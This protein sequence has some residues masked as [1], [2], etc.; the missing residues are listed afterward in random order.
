MKREQK[1][2][3]QSL[4]SGMILMLLT[5]WFL[6]LIVMIFAMIFLVTDRIDSQIERSIETS[7]QKAAEILEMQLEASETASKNA[8]YLSVIRNAYIS[9]QKGGDRGE[10]QNTI[11]SFI[12]Q[13]YKFNSNVKSVVLVFMEYPE[14][15][16]FTFNNSNNGTYNDIEFFKKHVQED[17]LSRSDELDTATE[18]HAYQGRVY[19]VRNLVD[20]KFQPYAVLAMELDNES[21]M[22][23]LTGIWGYEDAKIYMNGNQMISS[24]VQTDELGYSEEIKTQLEKNDLLFVKKA[25]NSSFVYKRLRLYNGDFDFAVKLNNSVIYAESQALKVFFVM[26]I[27]FMIPLVCLIFLFFHR[28]VN[29][30]IQRMVKAFD[31]VKGGEY[32]VQIE[33]RSHSEEFYHMEEAFN[34]MSSRLKEQFEKIYKEEIALRDARIMALQSQINPH[35]LNNSLEI[36]NWEARLNENYRV[37][38]M[39]EAL[40]TML[41]ATMNRKSQPFNTVSEEMTFVDAYLYIISQ[42]YGDKFKCKKEID[43]SLLGCVIPRLIIQPIVE[44]AVEHGMDRRNGEIIIR[45]YK[46]DKDLL[47]IEIEDNGSIDEEDKERIHK[48]L[49]EEIDPLNE[50]HVSLGIRNVDRRLKMH[51]GADCGLFITNNKKNHTVSTILVKI[52]QK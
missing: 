37:S 30:P 8:S 44:N 2:K 18:L 34:H 47:C 52:M 11:L 22:Q 14:E 45:L 41:E 39:I 40:S 25:G 5:G 50:K 49:T 23:G 36:I 29:R 13:Q 42:R 3:R 16:F 28:R 6:P 12:N 10:F 26:I 33:N 4:R 21:L 27:I 20:S 24:T 1:K 19:M 7:T 38:Q 31:V 46:K 51:Y 32:G 48:L 9:Y 17:L 43:E 15:N 35:F